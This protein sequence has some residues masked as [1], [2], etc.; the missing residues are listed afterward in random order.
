MEDFS[1]FGQRQLDAKTT[2]AANGTLRFHFRAVRGA[3][4]FDDGEP[5]SRAF[6]IGGTS[7][8]NTV[9]PLENMWQRIRGNADAVVFHF[10]HGVAVDWRERA[11][12]SRLF[13][14]C[15]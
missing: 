2:A 7:R 4:G 8:I 6:G 11:I 12:E 10:Q 5:K 15:I 1:V 14:A 3:N 13:P 9:K